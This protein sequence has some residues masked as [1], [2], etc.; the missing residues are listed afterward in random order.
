M[1]L[2]S[3]IEKQASSG[4]SLGLKLCKKQYDACVPQLCKIIDMVEN[5]G[6]IITI[7]CSIYLCVLEKLFK[8]LNNAWNMPIFGE[9][10]IFVNFYLVGLR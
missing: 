3:T 6:C 9:H 1:N 2:T 5:K 10:V 8:V 7:N 4:G